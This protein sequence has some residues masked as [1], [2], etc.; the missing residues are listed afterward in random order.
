MLLAAPL[1]AL[2]LAAAGSPGATVQVT[3]RG[4]AYEVEAA[5]ESHASPETAWLVLTDFGHIA[6]F[7]SSI[8]ESH[9]TRR[10]PD[11]VVVEQ[12][13]TA[14]LLLF[15][16]QMS[17][18]LEV[19]EVPARSMR[20]ADVLHADFRRYEGTWTL[21]PDGDGTRIEYR[22]SARP[23]DAVPAFVGVP[24]MEK[25]VSGMLDE[26]AGEMDRR[27]DAERSER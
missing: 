4:G 2:M 7:V 3:A 14:S 18:T 12:K 15:S 21:E 24:A 5:T 8:R 6:D 27:S 17:V 22:L 9:V 25:K 23:R 20:F 26:L 13:A 19:H 16:R 10:L 1:G 11:G